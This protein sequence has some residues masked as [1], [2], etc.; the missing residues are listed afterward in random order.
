MWIGLLFA[1]LSQ[2]MVSYHLSEDEPLEYMGISQSISELYRLRTAQCLMLGDISKCSPYTLETMVH[3]TMSEWARKT[4]NE[5]RVWMMVGLLVRVALQMGYHRWDYSCVMVVLPRLYNYRDPSHYPK[6]TICQGEIRRR[7]WGFIQG[8]DALTSFLVGLP[9]MIR[10]VEQDVAVPRNLHD[11]ELTEDLTELPP[12]RP[13]SEITSVSY[14][15]TKGRI[16]VTIGKIVDFMSSLHLW[17][18]ESVLKLDRQLEKAFQDIPEYFRMQSNPGDEEPSLLNRR[19]QL[20]FLY[21]QAVCVLHRKFVAQGRSDERFARSRSRCIESAMAL[22][23]QQ[24]YLYVESRIKRSLASKHWYRASYTSQEYTLAAMIVVLELRQRRL[25]VFSGDLEARMNDEKQ[26][27][28]ALEIACTIWHDVD[29]SPKAVKVYKVLTTMLIQ[30]RLASF[31][32]AALQPQ[33]TSQIPGLPT[34]E[35]SWSGATGLP[36]PDDM[37]IDWSV[38]PQALSSYFSY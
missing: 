13:S 23:T 21:H 14:L 3:Y 20:V 24:H 31:G 27:L 29:D 4:H 22:L 38:I 25:E 8:S 15:L 1:V 5:S 36:L 17:D 2:S 7:I 6:I 32:E 16:I 35:G 37:T 18:Y 26:M 19:I 33:D 30:L 12:S 9:G 11:W 10:S 34:E 28:K